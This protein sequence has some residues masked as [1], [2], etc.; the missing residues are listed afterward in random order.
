M[1]NT[2]LSLYYMKIGDKET[3][4]D[5]SGKATLKGMAR[6]RGRA[7]MAVDQDLEDGKRKDAARKRDM[8]RRVL[9]IDADDAIALFGLGNALLTLG[10]PD[11][12]ARHLARAVSTD[13][14]NSAVYVSLGK[15]FERLERTTEAVATYRAGLEVASRR[16]D[17]MPAREMEH[18]LLLLGAR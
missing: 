15:A 5:E 8:F 16:G 2:N 7:A 6:Q 3:A 11:G 14:N 4:E 13:K 9:E 1:V 12:A 10:D 17:L 18:R